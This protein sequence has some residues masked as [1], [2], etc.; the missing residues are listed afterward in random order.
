MTQSHKFTNRLAQSTSPYLLQHAHNPVDW[1]PWGEEAFE[2]AK[3]EDKPIFLSIGYSTCHWC[4]VMAHE[5]FEDEEVARL[6]NEDFIAIK[7]DREERPDIDQLYMSAATSI[8]GRGGWPLTIVMAADKRPFFA[9][10][11][12][13]KES[14]PGRVGMLDLLPRISS[15]WKTQRREIS[16]D[17]DQIMAL[18]KQQNESAS[19]DV[20]GLELLERSAKEYR[21][22]YDQLNGGF[23]S[24][25]KFPSPHNLV[26][27]LREGQRT[28]N[29]ELTEMALHTLTQIRLGGIF[30]HIGFGFHRYSTD[31]RW[32]VPHFEKML[33]DQANLM[34]AYT[35][36]WEVSG[37]PLFKQ[38]I[39]EIFL[40]LSDKLKSPGGAY[41]SAEDADS[42]GEEGKFYVWSWEELEK[43]IEGG[44]LT[45][46]AEAFGLKPAGNFTDEA[47]GQASAA[48]ILHL[49]SENAFREIAQSPKWEQLRLELYRIRE[50]RVHPGLDN[51]ILCDWNGF[52][53][54][55]L[56]RAAQA[57]GDSRYADAAKELAGY[58]L[59]EMSTEDGKLLHKTGNNDSD[60]IAGFLDDYSYT[61][62]GLRNYYEVSFEPKYLE[63][64][65]RLQKIQL[66][67]FWDEDQGGFF[68]SAEGETDLLIRQKEIYDGAMP[69]GNSIAA[70]NLYF[71][72]RISESKAWEL[73]SSRI[74]AAFSAQIQRSPR[75]FSALLQSTQVQVSGSKEIVIAG[76][77]KDLHAVTNALRNYYNPFTS[78]LYHPES[79]PEQIERISDFTRYQKS[80][81]GGLTV[82]ICEDYVCQQPLTDLDKLN[83]V[84][85][86]GTGK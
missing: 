43:E 55:A 30:D 62:Q 35:E 36:A 22:N 60:K 33:Y 71:L 44:Q 56:S 13:P 75:G 81:D 9:G 68:F 54:S 20:P 34:L 46:I 61:I 69:S 4:H 64:A 65:I 21:N 59:S 26:F 32:H 23:G 11:Y 16:S 15:A 76:S 52:V 14:S 2:K 28:G 49:E 72:G 53:L 58:L 10:T 70:L 18:L 37:N 3:R 38:T 50:G 48:N 79:D 82:Y 77:E 7:V 78:I 8:I 73:K 25:P 39:D 12:F 1:Y 17:M 74:G 66:D 31:S 42:E 83:T 27:L 24:A 29:T 51:K 5:S 47:S 40:Y 85:K 45:F 67:Q 80:I 6:L 86:Q 41:Y 57:T 84:L 63:E 19:G